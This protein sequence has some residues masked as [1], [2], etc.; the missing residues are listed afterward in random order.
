MKLWSPKR[1]AARS[2]TLAVFQSPAPTIASR[3]LPSAHSL[4]F[5][6][7]P[8]R[9]LSVSLEATTGPLGPQA[10]SKGVPKL[11]AVP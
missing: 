10:G 11:R 6:L 9:S 4:P 3:N 2:K 8:A 1:R 5:S 7:S